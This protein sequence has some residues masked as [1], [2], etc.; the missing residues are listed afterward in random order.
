V[1]PTRDPK[2]GGNYDLA[3]AIRIRAGAHSFEAKAFNIVA[4]GFFDRAMRDELAML[5]RTRSA[6]WTRARGPSR[7]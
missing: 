1:W 5:G 3:S 2:G 7:W 4:S 6:Y